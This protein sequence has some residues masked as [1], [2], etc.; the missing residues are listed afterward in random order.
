MMLFKENIATDIFKSIQ[1]YC[2]QIKSLKK[3]CPIV[4]IK[5]I[6]FFMGI[7]GQVYYKLKGFL[8]LRN[9][10]NVQITRNCSK[11]YDHKRLHYRK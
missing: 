10:Y 11:N 6:L 2:V 5:A 7:N 9:D 4:K 8:M 3:L 1:M